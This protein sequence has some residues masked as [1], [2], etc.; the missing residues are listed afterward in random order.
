MRSGVEFGRGF[1]RAVTVRSYAMVGD[2]KDSQEKLSVNVEQ[3]IFL[4]DALLL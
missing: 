1:Q 3:K 2:R 4:V